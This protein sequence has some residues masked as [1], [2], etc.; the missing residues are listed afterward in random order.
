MENAQDWD[1]FVVG[2]VNPKMARFRAMSLDEQ[3]TILEQS[4]QEALKAREEMIVDEV[5]EVP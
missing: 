3:T 1:E 5:V 2:M 4:S